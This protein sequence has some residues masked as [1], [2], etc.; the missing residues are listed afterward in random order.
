MILLVS[1]LT[2]AWAKLFQDAVIEAQAAR[3]SLGFLNT[4]RSGNTPANVFR[5][6]TTWAADNDCFQGLNRLSYER[7]L[8]IWQK[9]EP[10]PL[11]V[12]TPDVVA[13]ASAT[14]ERF[15]EWEPILHGMGYP[16][17]LV[18]QDG[19]ERLAVPWTRLEAVFVG[20]STTWKLSE[21]AASLCQEARQRGKWI[22]MGRVNSQ[23]RMETAARF[24]CQSIDGSGFSR[25]KKL[26]APGVRWMRRA[27]WLAKH[28]P[29]LFQGGET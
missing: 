9:V 26:I 14:L 23:R 27:E 8:R 1:G 15:E 22:H 11:W 19:Q 29:L 13:D 4:P 3:G 25:W 12:A 28:Q 10:G 2:G 16:V 7:M 21:H 24:G 20:G 5:Y 17:A 18:L 6:T